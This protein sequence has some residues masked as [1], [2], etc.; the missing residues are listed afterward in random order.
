MRRTHTAGAT[1][2]WQQELLEQASAAAFQQAY[3]Q[4]QYVQMAQMQFAMQGERLCCSPPSV[5]EYGDR[6]S[7]EKKPLAAKARAK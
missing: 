6:G 7:T 5:S 1:M 3:A 2:N 4:Q